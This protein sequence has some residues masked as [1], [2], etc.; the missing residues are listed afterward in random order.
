[1]CGL[2]VL[3]ATWQM[4]TSQGW[5]VVDCPAHSRGAAKARPH[6]FQPAC[7]CMDQGLRDLP[8]N[9]RRGNTA[10]AMGQADRKCTSRV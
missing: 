2:P 4:G 7:L 10:M 6:P 9:S 1:M 5:G 8:T 3:T